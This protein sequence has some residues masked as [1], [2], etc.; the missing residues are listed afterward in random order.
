MGL[1]FVTLDSTALVIPSNKR[2]EIDRF[3][4]HSLTTTI[5][6]VSL[7]PRFG[8]IGSIMEARE[9]RVQIMSIAIPKDQSKRRVDP[10]ESFTL[11]IASPGAKN[12]WI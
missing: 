3:H 10:K 6:N 11:I 4:Y 2:K 1:A 5:Y 8:Q 12:G 9:Y 7:W